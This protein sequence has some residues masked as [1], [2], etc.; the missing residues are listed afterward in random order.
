MLR[1]PVGGL[2]AARLIQRLLTLAALTGCAPKAP[3]PGGPWLAHALV[4]GPAPSGGFARYDPDL[5]PTAPD[6]RRDTPFAARRTAWAAEAALRHPNGRFWQQ[7]RVLHLLAR[8]PRVDP[9]TLLADQR[10]LEAWFIEQ[11]FP[12]AL[13]R[14]SL[15]GAERWW[16]RPDDPRWREVRYEVEPGPRMAWTKVALVGA[17]ELP[18]PVRAELRRALPRVGA[19]TGQQATLGA[20]LTH[21]LDDLGHPGRVTV[22]VAW[23]ES[24]G[25]LTVTVE[26]AAERPRVGEVRITGLDRLRGDALRQRVAR[27]LA[28]GTPW[29]HAVAD[30]LSASVATLPGGQ[31][32]E[33]IGRPQEDGSIDAEVRV[34]ELP[35]QVTGSATSVGATGALLSAAR[36]TRWTFRG[37][38]GRNLDAHIGVRAGWRLFDGPPGALFREMQTGPEAALRLGL[39]GLLSLP[40]RLTAFADATARLDAWR[41]HTQ[42]QAIAETGLRFRPGPHLT[43]DLGW[44]SALSHHLPFPTQQARFD[45]AF[46]EPGLGLLRTAGVHGPFLRVRHDSRDQGALSR[47]GVLATMTIRPWGVVA[48]RGE[49]WDF[50]RFELDVTAFKEALPGRLVLVGRVAGG[51]HIYDDTAGNGLLYNRFFLGGPFVMRGFGFRR[52]NPVGAPSGLADVHPGGDA[53]LIASGEARVR[54]HPDAAVALFGDVGR[55]WESGVDRIEGGRVVQRGVRLG[56]VQPVAGIGAIVRTPVGVIGAY[57]GVRLLPTTGMAEEPPRAVF[58]FQVSPGGA[59]L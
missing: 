51:V 19:W 24:G 54:V 45:L 25:V 20:R 30:A 6:S 29:S 26:A 31:E 49:S 38:G 1:R 37:L 27:L 15:R 35:R 55:V 3:P 48:G 32:V 9:P 43:M 39:E 42:V 58:T 36:G 8:P 10:R 7:A 44:E 13:V 22:G 11:G 50:G 17:G 53:M 23:Q 57:L 21:L 52:L 2:V 14:A 46:G 40:A 59:A 56:D 41:G 16:V 12:F 47:R 34:L 18:V 5:P 33:V 28:P 4:E